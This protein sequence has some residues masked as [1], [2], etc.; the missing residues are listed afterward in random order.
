MGYTYQ[1]SF[2]NNSQADFIEFHLNSLQISNYASLDHLENVVNNGRFRLL[3]FEQNLL[4]WVDENNEMISISFPAILD[5][6]GCYNCIPPDFVSSSTL[7]ST[8]KQSLKKKVSN[9]SFERDAKTIFQL[10]PLQETYEN[11]FSTEAIECC[12]A[13]INIIQRIYNKAESS[14]R[15]REPLFFFLIEI[16]TKKTEKRLPIR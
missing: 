11:I 16:I 1:D 9:S 6:E 2:K 5:L 13:A 10:S 15:N 7:F 8:R 12:T 14:I 4:Q 3:S